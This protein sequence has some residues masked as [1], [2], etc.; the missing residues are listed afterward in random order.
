MKVDWFDE[1]DS[2][3][4]LE[5]AGVIAQR[6]VA[7]EIVSSQKDDRMPAMIGHGIY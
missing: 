2:F 7:E 6:L 1:Q 5:V 3:H 4:T